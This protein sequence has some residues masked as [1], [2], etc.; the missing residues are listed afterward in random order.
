MAT[1][2][3][4]AEKGKGLSATSTVVWFL[5]IHNEVTDPRFN[6]NN[7]QLDKKAFCISKTHY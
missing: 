7:R 2:Q 6:V 3:H 5:K 4:H 1:T